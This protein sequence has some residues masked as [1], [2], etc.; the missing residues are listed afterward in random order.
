MNAV[1]YRKF[2][3]TLSAIMV[4]LAIFSISVWGFK[5][6]LDFTG[7]SLLE[8]TY[9]DSRPAL[10][11]VQSSLK[12][13]G[14]ENASVRETGEKGYI[15]RTKN[16]SDKDIFALENGLSLG[17]TKSFNRDRLTSIGPVIGQ[18]LKQ[19][20]WIAIVFI[21][22]ITVI[23]I[24]IAFRHVG[25]SLKTKSGKTISSWHYGLMSI[26][27]LVHDIA[28]PAGVFS[29][30]GHFAGVEVDALFVTA[31]LALL[32]YSINDTIVIFDRI[33]ENLKKNADHSVREEFE[34]TVGKSLTQTYGRSINT[35]MT[36]LIVLLALLFL[37]G[38]ATFYFILALTV[39]V[40]AGAYSSIF[41]AAP[42]LVTV[43]KW[44]ERKK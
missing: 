22:L 14:F 1:R 34:F 19:K 33:R 17:G 41:L 40:V 18:E 39:G 16:L 36:T 15:V 5:F 29:V 27:A 44:Y 11:E 26:V 8:I 30:L 12:N 10:P 3:Y 23:Y 9:T 35:S 43:E 4:G 28:I 25:D 21:I 7:G 13:A 2:F 20:A 38:G 42:L 32:G 6:G 24:A 31:L 37:G